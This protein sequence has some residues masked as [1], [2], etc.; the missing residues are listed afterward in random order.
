MINYYSILG[1]TQE[2]TSI[3]IKKA[4]R[5]LAKKYHPDT[6]PNNKVAQEKFTTITA[7][8]EVLSDE[9]KR[10]EYDKKFNLKNTR[11]SN[12]SKN[13]QN[14]QTTSQATE[15]DFVKTRQAFENFFGF[16]ASTGE[17]VKEEK[18]K[19]NKNPLDTTDMFERFMGMK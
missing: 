7:A 13:K 6:N 19:R 14:S 11:Q 1:I 17:I 4:Y 8:Y 18:L 10:Q 5:S 12:S 2:A 3:E 15:F 9:K 16:D